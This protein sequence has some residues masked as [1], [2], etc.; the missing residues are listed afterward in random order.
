MT[1]ELISR[2]EYWL[3]SS[4][5]LRPLFAEA[6]MFSPAIVVGQR[7]LVTSFADVTEVL[8]HPDFG[9]TEVYAARMEHTT[10]AFFL[11][12]D[13]GPQ[14]DREASLAR[15]AVRPGD[16]ETVRAIARDTAIAL[17]DGARGAGAIDAVAGFSRIIP[18][19]IVQQYFGVPGPNDTDLK[20]WMRAIFWEIFLDTTNDP[21]VAAAAGVASGELAP[22]LVDL[23]QAR[24]RERAA[25][26]RR[27]DYL[28]RLVEQQ[29]DPAG[30]FDDDGLRRNI[31]GI[32][33]GAVDTQSKAMAHALEQ[34]LKRPDALQIALG[35]I[36][37]GD[38]ALLARCVFEAL[39]FDPLTPI[40]PRMCHVQHVLGQG[41]P[42]A[43]VIPEGTM[44]FAATLAAMF[45]PDKVEDP[46]TFR[47]D[48]P[49][50]NY[51][52]FGFGMHRCFGERFND[53]VLPE[54][55]KAILP[56][57]NLRLDG[58]VTYEG[59]FPDHMP[60]RFDR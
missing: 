15:R 51:L 10:G 5:V 33:T 25:G 34:L 54:A 44:V 53:V 18:I 30:G 52:Q 39:R 1:S 47:T 26:A 19:R 59:P 48:R 27:D 11:G 23:I 9:V 24:K 58:A 17:V 21:A 45:D 49:A 37:D 8:G 38:D 55:I 16:I 41:K 36:R 3:G 6:R 42:H 4:T 57:L 14:Y 20:R 29:G 43:T 31:G 35:A 56:L 46:D 40:L 2:I 13:P 22:Y 7:A 28:S 12:M 60:L 50:D 32:I